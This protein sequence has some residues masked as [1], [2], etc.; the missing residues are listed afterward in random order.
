MKLKELTKAKI[1]AFWAFIEHLP[2][3]DEGGKKKHFHVY[4]EPS[5][6]CQTEDLREEF[7]EYDPEMPD[8]PRGINKF[9]T[10]NF[11]NWYMYALHDAR[12]LASKGEER[13]YHYKHKD[14]LASDEDDLTFMVRTI[15]TLALSPYE[16]MQQAIENGLSWDEY[17]RRGIVPIQMFRQWR[18]AW[19]S[20]F[21]TYYSE[22]RTERNG[23]KNHS[24][25]VEE[26]KP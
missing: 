12:Y 11:D 22:P 20:L 5:K 14:V 8:K 7:R 17:V 1:L 19:D 26:E 4:M 24:M 3:D 16:D 13:K 2:E 21:H 6:L 15:N 23:H 18:M 9:V 25:D 10:S